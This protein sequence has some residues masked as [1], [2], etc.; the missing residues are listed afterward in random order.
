MLT[1]MGAV[2]RRRTDCTANNF[3]GA[4]AEAD[5]SRCERS[6]RPECAGAMKPLATARLV[7]TRKRAH[8]AI[9]WESPEVFP[10]PLLNTLL[11]TRSC[12][13]AREQNQAQTLS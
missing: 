7:A 9:A 10:F 3:D 1:A 13:S 2:V 12:W 4:N 6:A 11:R 5:M 8:R